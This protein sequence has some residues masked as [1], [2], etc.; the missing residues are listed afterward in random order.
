MAFLQKNTIN[1]Q[2]Q[3]SVKFYFLNSFGVSIQNC[4]ENIINVT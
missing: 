2:I 1:E 3:T 4:L